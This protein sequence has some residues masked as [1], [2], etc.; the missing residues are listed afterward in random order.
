MAC[1]STRNVRNINEHFL[2]KIM[3]TKTASPSVAADPVIVALNK[4]LANTYALMSQTHLAHWNVEGPDFFQLHGAFETQ[5]TALFEASDE[6]AEQVR[7]LGGYAEGGL[8][9]LAEIADLT[10]LPGGRVAAKDMVAHLIEGHE[11]CSAAAKEVENVS[12]EADDLESQDLAIA[13]RQ[14]HQK[15]IWMLTSFLK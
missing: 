10:P 14:F 3:S 8:K 4:L 2:P 13:R 1:A 5:Y 11:K 12:G 9:R 7:S 6:V 15:T